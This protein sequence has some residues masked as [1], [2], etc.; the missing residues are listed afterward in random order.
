MAIVV[1][2]L[3]VSALTALL[4]VGR[5]TPEH[6]PSPQPMSPP[7]ELTEALS[8][9]LEQARHSQQQSRDVMALA[10]EAL[11]SNEREVSRDR[12]LNS[13]VEMLEKLNLTTGNLFLQVRSMGLPGAN[14]TVL[15]GRPTQVGE[16]PPGAPP[17]RAS[18]A[19]VPT[20]SEIV[21][22][23]ETETSSPSAASQVRA[24]AFPE[25]T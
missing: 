6:S 9:L 2:A 4:L 19:H 13:M 5:R 21:E 1:L 24:S 23:L 10:I 17:M 16:V 15:E 12:S 25:H 8:L 20:P 3:A 14:R 7:P 22:G 11:A 18:R